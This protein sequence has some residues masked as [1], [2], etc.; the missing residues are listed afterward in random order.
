MMANKIIF[1]LNFFLCVP[2]YI[3]TSYVHQINYYWYMI[4]MDPAGWQD[5]TQIL[6]PSIVFS[7][8]Y[9]NKLITFH[10]I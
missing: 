2:N 6:F 5:Q 4:M 9:Y 7:I 3:Q 1:T 10:K 8:W